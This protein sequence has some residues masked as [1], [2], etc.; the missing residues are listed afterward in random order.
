VQ[1]G[2]E[3]YHATAI[4]LFFISYFPFPISYLLFPISYLLFPI[5]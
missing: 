4:R 3:T 5:S 1:L 2:A